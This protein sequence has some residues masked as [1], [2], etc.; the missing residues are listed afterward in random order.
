[1]EELTMKGETMLMLLLL[2]GAAYLLYASTKSGGETAALNAAT[3][4]PLPTVMP[5]NV[6]N[7]LYAIPG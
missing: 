2:G 7:A 5:S 3:I 6:A 1:L 4:G